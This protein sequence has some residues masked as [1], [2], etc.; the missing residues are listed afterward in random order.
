MALSVHPTELALGTL[1]HLIFLG[2]VK[3]E[4]FEKEAPRGWYKFEGWE[5]MH[6]AEFGEAC[7]WYAHFRGADGSK[8]MLSVDMITGKEHISNLWLVVKK[9]DPLMTNLQEKYDQVAGK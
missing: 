8:A 9:N 4:P 5:R 6:L 2:D 1:H 7:E 3:D